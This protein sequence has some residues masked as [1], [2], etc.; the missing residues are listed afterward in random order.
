MKVCKFRITDVWNFMFVLYFYL[1]IILFVLKC[2]LNQSLNYIISWNLSYC[3]SPSCIKYLKF[4]HIYVNDEIKGIELANEIFY[5]HVMI[6]FEILIKSYICKTC[7]TIYWKKSQLSWSFFSWIYL[8]IYFFKFLIN[9]FKLI[10]VLFWI[11]KCKIFLSVS[12][13]LLDLLVI[14]YVISHS[15]ISNFPYNASEF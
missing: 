8:F 13:F 15:Q 6:I 9:F 3:K 14:K 10:Y 11:P 2:T 12:T 7:F 4:Y 1:L 5:L